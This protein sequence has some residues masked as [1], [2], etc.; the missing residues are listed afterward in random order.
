MMAL[1]LLPAGAMPAPRVSEVLAYSGAF[2]G[3]AAVALDTNRFVVA[4]DEDSTLR[5]Y[6]RDQGG[7]PVQT[8]DLVKFLKVRADDAET[9]IE[10]A[11]RVGHRV[12]WISS[13]GRNQSGRERPHHCRFFATDIETKAADVQLS[14]VGEPCEGLLRD[15][16]AS[17]SLR[18]FN[19]AA[20][21]SRPPKS[22]GGMSI[23]GLAATPD[24]HLLIGFRNPV[25]QG[26]ALLVP[27]LNPDEVIEGRHARFGAPIQMN[28]SGLG[29]RDIA[30]WQGEF[31]IIGGPPDG[32]GP[33]KLYRWA[34]DDSLPKPIK[35][36]SLKG[37]HPEAVVIYPDKGLREFQLFSDDSTRQQDTR[38][39]AATA[40]I[41]KHF[42]SA[43]VT[44]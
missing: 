7:A 33:F 27:L 36:V 3:S 32:G 35:H 13:H 40:V 17:A 10:G 16:I 22:P 15:L 20:A 31:I 26:R 41:E 29:I 18:T 24:K 34:G 21:A 30:S 38:F 14:P 12:Y 25:P 37:L 1:V 9:D 11:A 43:W 19:L 4:S 6:L 2:D 28:L 39:N 5:I 23:E 44:P 8:V 42:R